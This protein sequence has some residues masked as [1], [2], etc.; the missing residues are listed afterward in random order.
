MS[1]PKRPRPLCFLALPAIVVAGCASGNAEGASVF[2]AAPASGEQV[3]GEVALHVVLRP[4]SAV[5]TVDLFV[6]DQPIAWST[7][8]FAA[9]EV[10]SW[11]S[12]AVDNGIHELRVE[13]RFR[14]RGVLSD[15]VYVV[16]D[17]ERTGV[18]I[19]EPLSRIYREDEV[20]VFGVTLDASAD[21]SSLVLEVDGHEV[22]RVDPVTSVTYT[23]LVSTREAGI[24]PDTERVELVARATTRGG[25]VREARRTLD[26]GSRRLW[27]FETLGR[28]WER[29]EPLPGG[30]VAVL[31]ATGVLHVVEPDGTERCHVRADGEDGIGAPRYVPE[32][33]AVAWGTSR[34]LWLHAVEDCAQRYV[35]PLTATFSAR[36]AVGPGGRVVAV[37][38]D[39]RLVSFGSDGGSRS[40]T[41]LSAGM[42]GGE[43]LQVWGAPAVAPDGTVFVLGQVGRGG[44][45][46]A[47]APDGMVRSEDVTSWGRGGLLWRDGTLY[48]AGEDGTTYAY[49]EDLTR[50][51]I[52]TG[53]DAT[54]VRALPAFDGVHVVTENGEGEVRALDPVTGETRWTF[55]ATEGTGISGTS[56]IGRAGFAASPGQG[57]LA[58]ADAV[59]R[60]QVLRSDGIRLLSTKLAEGSTGRGI[61]AAP[62]FGEGRLFV[63]LEEQSLVALDV[64]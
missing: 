64:R 52:A 37:T 15:S 19:T 45:L 28:I 43:T 29:P 24:G 39:G 3:S 22:D 8:P 49:G 42:S 34:H 4:P 41:D 13:A 59:G 46:F 35:D 1:S 9:E 6:D 58:F 56:V 50:R 27:A 54:A 2:L 44:V 62:A 48:F 14:G 25:L 26:V 16:V 23:V 38:L 11:D 20:F 18:R 17:N 51:W 63:G 55:D 40:E 12:T 30:A 47:V 33:E 21:V 36:P 10:V 57:L 7:G 31:T 61:V 5:Q 53:G 32:A 60:V